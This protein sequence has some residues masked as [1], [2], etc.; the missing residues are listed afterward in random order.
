MKKLFA[1]LLQPF[2][3]KVV[4]ETPLEPDVND[5]VIKDFF[6]NYFKQREI[7]ET[8][9]GISKIT[10]ITFENEVKIIIVLS[11]PGLLIGK[12]G[13]NVR[14]LCQQIGELVN[15]PVTIR[16]VESNPLS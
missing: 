12:A 7:D 15:K 14:S 8:W 5:K 10:T 3:T 1:F 6:I 2:R 13:H 16:T 11:R 4:N 9:W